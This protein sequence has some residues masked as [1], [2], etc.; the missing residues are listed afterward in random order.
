MFVGAHFETHN[1]AMVELP[2]ESVIGRMSTAELR[3]DDPRISEAHALISLRGA[4]LRLLALRGRLSVDGKPATDVKLAPGVR[5]VLAGF[6]PLLVRAVRLP[7]TVPAVLGPAPTDAPFPALG[8]V[9][10]FPG[11]PSPLR[12]GF[13]PTAAAH[14]WIA[15]DG[16]TLRLNEPIT[17]EDPAPSH[18]R[19]LDFD[20]QFTVAGHTYTLTTT[21]LGA[22]GIDATVD[23]GHLDAAL[24]IHLRYDT[25]R[26]VG[27]H[28][29]TCTLDGLRA[30]TLAELH[31]IGQ[32]VSWQELT[33]LL[34]DPS[35]SLTEPQMRQRWDQLLTRI[36][37]K[38]RESG[39]RSDLIRS[40]RPGLVELVLGPDDVVIDAS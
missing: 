33:R 23:T 28:G 31:A 4:E 13:D 14:L 16:A 34:W 29:R 12:H 20:D 35:E 19:I 27:A 10:F 17:L 9:A 36:R 22:L 1:G 21:E 24:T 39:I 15:D 32:P 11:T 18:D 2:P 6:Y 26:V 8:V 37:T 30:R 3:I 5:V 7:D 25:A 40:V 38:L